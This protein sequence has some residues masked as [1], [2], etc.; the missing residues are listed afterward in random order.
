MRE[1]TMGE[2]ARL[3]KDEKL[4]GPHILKFNRED[5]EAIAQR[6][7]SDLE[8]RRLA[9]AGIFFYDLLAFLR[10]EMTLS[11]LPF[12]PSASARLFIG[13]ATWNYCRITVQ[14][15]R[16]VPRPGETPVLM[17]PSLQQ[18]QIPAAAGQLF[19]PNELITGAGNELKRMLAELQTF[20]T[21][22]TLRTEYDATRKDIDEISLEFN[23]QIMYSCAVEYWFDCVGYGY[24]LTNSPD[25]IAH[26]PFS[27]DEEIARIVSIYR[28]LHLYHRDKFLIYNQWAHQ[29]S[30]KEKRKLC[31]IPLVSQVSFNLD[32]IESIEL[33]QNSRVLSSAIV[34]LVL[35]R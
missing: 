4:P 6:E 31:E 21:N 10:S 24:G 8:D 34:A 9:W 2:F 27:Q 15:D 18:V 3:V 20:P 1:V 14:A 11:T 29:L 17:W 32:R 16:E 13:L 22:Q 23:R 19:D 12:R 28:R 30:D 26:V 33:S 7:D 35:L 5:W 25:G